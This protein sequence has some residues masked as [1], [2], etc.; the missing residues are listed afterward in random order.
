MANTTDPTQLSTYKPA[1]ADDLL[2]GLTQVALTAAGTAWSS[3][4]DDVSTH[5]ALIAKFTIETKAK[6]AI[7]EIIDKE[8]DQEMTLLQ[9]DLN[10]TLLEATLLP[11]IIGQK[12]LDAVTSVVVAVIKN[13]TGISLNF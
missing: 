3:I 8:A 13:Y 6:L 1:S 2:K 10:N 12:V 9:L 7:G 5:L 11:Y 4:K